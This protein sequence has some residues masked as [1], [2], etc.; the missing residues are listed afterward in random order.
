VPQKDEPDPARKEKIRLK[1][2]KVLARRYFEYADAASLTHLLAVAKGDG[3]IR[4]LYNGR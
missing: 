3:D 1:L 4:I 2:L